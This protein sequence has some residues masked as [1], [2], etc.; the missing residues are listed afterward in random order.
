MSYTKTQWT[1]DTAPAINETNLNKIEQGIYD[2]DSAITTI[3]TNIGDL[4][5]LETTTQ[6]D[7]V[8]AINENV[9]NVGDL[10]GLTTTA[11]TD[12]VSAINEVKGDI[13]TKTSDLTNDSN[14]ITNQVNG[15]FAVSGQSAFTGGIRG[16]TIN[17]GLGTNGYFYICDVTTTSNYQNQAIK[18]DVL[19]RARHGTVFITLS[20]LPTTGAIGVA[21][22]SCTGNIAPFYVLTNNVVKIYLAKSESY[23][24]VEICNLEKGSYMNST[25]ITWVN[26]TVT[27]LPTG[28]VFATQEI[29]VPISKLT[30]STTLSTKK[31]VITLTGVRMDCLICLSYHLGGGKNFGGSLLLNIGYGPT[32]VSSATHNDTGFS[33][34]ASGNGNSSIVVTINEDSITSGDIM[35]VKAYRTYNY[36]E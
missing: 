14:F 28:Y 21:S 18:F 3:N 26:Q 11:N 35:I 34:S 33:V 12:L 19:Q 22:F 31:A 7:I 9:D 32:I 30:V 36:T 27:T 17:E 8:S 16:K 20:S 13:P 23:D 4:T 15:N 29:P 2:N 5:D 24:D 10:S 1:N 6:T 25:T